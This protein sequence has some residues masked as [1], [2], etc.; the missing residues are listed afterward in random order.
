[1]GHTE[2]VLSSARSLVNWFGRRAARAA[3]ALRP[4][5]A[6]R[7]PAER[8]VLDDIAMRRPWNLRVKLARRMA[9]RRSRNDVGVTVVIVSWNTRDVLG[10][11][12]YAAQALSE[13][14]VKFLVID[15]GST[16][17]TVEMLRRWPGVETMFLRS[18]A[19]H[20]IALDLG[21]C[22]VRTP[23]AVTLDSDAIPLGTDWLAPA[24]EPVRAGRAVLAGQRSRRDFVHPIYAAINVE[25]FLR[26]RLSFQVHRIPGD[27]ADVWGA[28]AFDTGEL[29]TRRLPT[30]DV[31]F[32]ERTEND[33]P[34]LPGMTAGGVVYHHGGV[35]RSADGRVTPGAYAAWRDAIAALGVPL[36]PLPG[37]AV[38]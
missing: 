36:R 3:A 1:M 27:D 22:A 31:E 15:N 38:A 7:A 6:T 9:L 18:N 30:D 14:D 34:G 37:E 11:V 2:A 33:A 17:G 32:V 25:A 26:R 35:S 28:N 10:D 20:G 29:L 5:A 8:N 13:G 23:I 16:D 19:G 4:S 21:I 12:L 24:V